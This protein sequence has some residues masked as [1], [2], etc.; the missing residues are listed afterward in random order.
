MVLSGQQSITYRI[1]QGNLD[2]VEA[3]ATQAA[4]TLR[5]VVIV[6][7]NTLNFAVSMAA[8][9]PALSNIVAASIQDITSPTL[10]FAFSFNN[11]GPTCLVRPGSLASWGGSALQIVYV[12]NASLTSALQLLV[13]V[14]GS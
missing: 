5:S 3:P 13:V 14:T 8:L 2:Y 12:S 10:G 1:R 4:M 11:S 7:I 9:F 6:P